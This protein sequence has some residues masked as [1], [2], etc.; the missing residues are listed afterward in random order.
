[1]NFDLYRGQKIVLEFG[2]LGEDITGWQTQLTIR[3]SARAAD[4]PALQVAG[5]LQGNPV[6]EQLVRVTLT[7]AQTLTLAPGVYAFACAR[8]NAGE[9]TP[10]TVGSVTVYPDIT[11]AVS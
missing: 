9:E 11:H 3:S 8:I 7:K 4:P 1:M 5:S 6:T 2:P 10:L